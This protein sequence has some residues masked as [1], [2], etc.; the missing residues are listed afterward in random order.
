MVNSWL[1]TEPRNFISYSNRTHLYLFR[2]VRL[3][4]WGPSVPELTTTGLYRPVVVH[5]T[6]VNYFNILLSTYCKTQL[7]VF[8]QNIKVPWLHFKH[9]GQE[10]GRAGGPLTSPSW[11]VAKEGRVGKKTM[12]FFNILQETHSFI[13]V[14]CLNSIPTFQRCPVLRTEHS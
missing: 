10:P 7:I 8:Y 1:V 12:Y 4:V 3:H 5:G 2:N 14:I 11:L 6:L 9:S 13:T